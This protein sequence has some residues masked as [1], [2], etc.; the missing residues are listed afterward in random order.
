MCNDSDAKV[1]AGLPQE[2]GILTGHCLNGG[3]MT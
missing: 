2:T 1:G 3:H